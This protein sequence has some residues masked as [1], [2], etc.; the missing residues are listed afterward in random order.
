MNKPSPKHFVYLVFFIILAYL[1]NQFFIQAPPVSTPQSATPTAVPTETPQTT[2]ADGRQVITADNADQVVELQ[3]LGL[4]S[5]TEL[6]ISPDDS[7]LAVASTTGMRVY[8]LNTF[9]LLFGIDDNWTE[10]VDWSPDSQKLV[11]GHRDGTINIWDIETGE[12]TN[13]IKTDSSIFESKFESVA[14]SPDGNKIASNEYTSIYIWDAKTLEIL[15]EYNILTWGSMEWLSDNKHLSIHTGYSLFFLDTQTGEEYKDNFQSI[16]GDDQFIMGISTGAIVVIYNKEGFKTISGDGFSKANSLI[17]WEETL[18]STYGQLIKYNLTTKEETLIM[19]YDSNK[20]SVLMEW[21]SDLS[22]FVSGGIYGE[23][24]L[25]DLSTSETL[26]TIPGYYC[27]FEKMAWSP[28]NNQLSYSTGTS[29]QNLFIWD[30][31]QDQVAP[32]KSQTWDFELNNNSDISIKSHDGAYS[33]RRNRDGDLWIQDAITQEEIFSFESDD[34]LNYYIPASIAWSPTAPLLAYNLPDG[35]A[36]WD[37][38]TQEQV[39][40][41]KGYEGGIEEITWSAD[42]TQFATIGED[43]T[44]RIWGIP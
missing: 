1:A 23:L 12:I 14:W 41:I 19:E 18:F 35:L 2:F 21:T 43:Q 33:A 42:G 15:T 8:D 25:V 10:S 27:C 5:V 31:L 16:I 24:T 44:I 38:T 17:E 20:F 37:V 3:R 6:N 9:E 40:F 11:S 29:E 4:G 22:I 34:N 30:F 7:M 36:I 28:K 39:A 26:G 13:N 32:A